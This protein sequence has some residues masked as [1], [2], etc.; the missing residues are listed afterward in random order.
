MSTDTPTAPPRPAVKFVRKP[1]ATFGGHVQASAI[2][3][4]I[5]HNGGPTATAIR[6]NELRMEGTKPT[7]QQRVGGWRAR[8][9]A[10]PMAFHELGQMMPPGMT[11]TDLFEDRV[12]AARLNPDGPTQD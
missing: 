3:A 8:G 11:T 12:I 5:E 6:I 10:S 4:L 2:A 1:A 9:W 7:P